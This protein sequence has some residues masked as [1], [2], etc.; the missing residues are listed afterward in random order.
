MTIG[1]IVALF[2]AMTIIAMAPDASAAAVI[3]RSASSGFTRG[4]VVVLGIIIGDIVFI[5]LVFSGLAFIAES[6]TGAFLVIKVLGATYLVWMGCS[7]FAGRPTAPETTGAERSTWLSDLT[8]G[9]LITLGDPKAIVFYLSFLPAYL[10]LTR[11]TIGDAVLVFLIAALSI[12]TAKGGYAWFA[13]KT[14]TGFR[15]LKSAR[16]INV[17]SGGVMICTAIVLLWRV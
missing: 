14:G 15:S 8:C 11:A 5:A 9:L 1:S 12:A 13:D 17:L 4:L 6:M 16:I 2:G 10:D 3:A 7:L